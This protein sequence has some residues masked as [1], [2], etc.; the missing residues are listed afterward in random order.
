MDCRSGIGPSKMIGFQEIALNKL[1][2]PEA[3]FVLMPE[4]K[5]KRKLGVCLSESDG[6]LGAFHLL[7]QDVSDVQGRLARVEAVLERLEMLMLRVEQLIDQ[8]EDD[9][10]EE[11]DD[12]IGTLE[13]SSTKI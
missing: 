3:F 7:V 1:A 11:M 6:V 4:D 8:D 2:F 10:T 13:L 9:L 12:E 5:G